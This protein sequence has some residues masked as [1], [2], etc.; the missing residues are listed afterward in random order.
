[1]A[2]FLPHPSFSAKVGITVTTALEIGFYMLS[3]AIMCMIY[4]RSF[5]KKVLTDVVQLVSVCLFPYLF[6]LLLIIWQYPPPFVS[7]IHFFFLTS[8]TV[9]LSAYLQT[10]FF[11]VVFV[12]LASGLNYFLYL[13]LSHFHITAVHL[14]ASTG[15]NE[16]LWQIG[17]DLASNLY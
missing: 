2:F 1:M 17:S 4:L 6:F 11:A 5:S 7:V 16:R 15:I 10:T 9:A 8:A 3:I 12:S 13:L 14:F